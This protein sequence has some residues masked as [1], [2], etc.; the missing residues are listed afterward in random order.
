[1]VRYLLAVLAATSILPAQAQWSPHADPGRC[2]NASG[3][4]T[5][6]S[7]TVCIGRSDGVLI[8]TEA[9]GGVDPT[10]PVALAGLPPL[11]EALRYCD[12]LL[13]D[14]DEYSTR[15]FC[16]ESTKDRDYPAVKAAL[17]ANPDSMHVKRCISG[18]IRKASK[19]S[20]TRGF[21][22]SDAKGCIRRGAQ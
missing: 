22:S 7:S 15:M 21:N 3:Y 10:E 17:E 18:A 6:G 14:G 5:V 8:S 1:M 2:L 19:F 20:S 4:I 11:S 9:S 13:G 16:R 12:T